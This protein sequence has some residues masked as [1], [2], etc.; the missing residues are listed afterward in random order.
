MLDNTLENL[1][2]RRTVVSIEALSVHRPMAGTVE[3]LS[4][5]LVDVGQNIDLRLAGIKDT[6]FNTDV[7]T[8]RQE[9]VFLQR[10]AN[11]DYMSIADI[12]VPVTPGLV[13]TWIDFLH[14]LGPGV[15]FSTR[16]LDDIIVPFKKHLAVALSNPEQFS[17]SSSVGHTNLIDFELLHKAL[18][19]AVGGNSRVAVRPYGQCVKR[20]ADMGEVLAMTN[21]YHDALAKSN[22]DLISSE[23]DDLRKMVDEL[24]GNITDSNQQFR[25]NGKTIANISATAYNVAEAIEYYAVVR[26]LFTSHDVAMR[27]AVTKLMRNV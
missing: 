11:T 14:A 4:N 15:E 25:L 5:F 27:E 16:L 18:K 23:I 17:S 12:R 1:R 24:S 20:N 6:I 26:T 3:K 8:K 10:L 7:K 2:H 22:P 19:A 13:V 21:N 9:Q